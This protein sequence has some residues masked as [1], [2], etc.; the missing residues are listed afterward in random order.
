MVCSTEV[1]LTMLLVQA[2]QGMYLALLPHDIDGNDVDDGFRELGITPLQVCEIAGWQR[3]AGGLCVAG[4]PWPE[5][6]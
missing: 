4:V 5:V 2:E 1:N 6:S 3:A